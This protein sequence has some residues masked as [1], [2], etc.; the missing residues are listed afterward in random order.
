MPLLTLFQRTAVLKD[1]DPLN[2]RRVISL[3]S[4]HLVI[5]GRFRCNVDLPNLAV[6][7]GPSRIAGMILISGLNEDAPVH[8][9]A[10]GGLVNN[11]EGA[12][13]RIG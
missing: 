9:G 11:P 2:V 6:I 12:D 5:F 1:V 13:F 7:T 8:A 3:T 10:I 4:A